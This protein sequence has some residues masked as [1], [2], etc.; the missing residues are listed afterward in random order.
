MTSF[1]E[2]NPNVSEGEMWTYESSKTEDLVGGRTLHLDL[3]SDFNPD[4]HRGWHGP[5]YR[6]G[7]GRERHHPCHVARSRR[8]W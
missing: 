2:G 5:H 8:T 3:R 1:M 7:A 6:P 4:Q